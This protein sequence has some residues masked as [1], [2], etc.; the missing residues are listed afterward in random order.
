[1]EAK[2]ISVGNSKGI[3]IPAK[4]LKILGLQDKVNLKIDGNKLLITPINKKV[5]EGWEEIIV[6]EICDKGQSEKLLPDLFEDE[7]TGDWTW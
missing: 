5:R 3:I 2:V 4:L 7:E 6:N 1:M